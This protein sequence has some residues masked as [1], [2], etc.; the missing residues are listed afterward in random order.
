M[1]HFGVSCIAFYSVEAE[2]MSYAALQNL[3]CCGGPNLSF[4]IV[5]LQEDPSAHSLPEACESESLCLVGI[6]K[7]RL[8]NL[9]ASIHS[10]V[11][12]ILSQQVFIES[13]HVAEPRP[14][15][16]VLSNYC[17]YHELASKLSLH[18]NP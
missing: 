12:N 10:D 18:Q 5:D 1:L 15:S 9:S 11:N 8:T 14:P 2:T 17:S 16:A 3:T 7:S 6:K 4:P 13:H